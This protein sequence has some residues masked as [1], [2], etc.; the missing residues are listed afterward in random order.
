MTEDEFLP[1]KIGFVDMKLQN[2]TQLVLHLVTLL[3]GPG[4]L[5]VGDSKSKDS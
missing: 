1:D 2:L 5:S 3:L 4:P